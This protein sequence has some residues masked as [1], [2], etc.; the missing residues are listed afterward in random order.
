MTWPPSWPKGE[1]HFKEPISKK[2]VRGLK[3]EKAVGKEQQV[4]RAVKAEDKYCR[5]PLCNCKKFKLRQDTCHLVHR[6]QGGNPAGD[7]T[8]PEIL[9]VL[10][11]AR[12]RE[13][14]V[15]LDRSTLQIRPLTEHGMRGP[16]AFDVD[17]A[18]IKPRAK[19]RWIE[20][21]RETARHVYEPFT[22]EQRAILT[23]LAE[24]TT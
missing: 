21:A 24:M 17:A 4:M 6:G 8:K 14:I 1:T 20:V 2:V 9:I 15:S 16:C 13:N 11:S 23:R 5:W 19:A 7:R 22:V 10:C 18:S 3:R 12:H